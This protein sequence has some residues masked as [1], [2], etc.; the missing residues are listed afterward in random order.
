MLSNFYE[1]DAIAGPFYYIIKVM[2]KEPN[3]RSNL[4]KYGSNTQAIDSQDRFITPG[5]HG[6]RNTKTRM[7]NWI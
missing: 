3:K 4:K 5:R 1:I 6:H 7:M 2:M